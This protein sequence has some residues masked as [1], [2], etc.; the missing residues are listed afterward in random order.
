MNSRSTSASLGPFVAEE[1]HFYLGP[2]RYSIFIFS[3]SSVNRTM[4]VH[5][6]GRDL[7]MRI[8]LVAWSLVTIG[9]LAFARTAKE[10][11]GAV[12]KGPRLC[13]AHC[14]AGNKQS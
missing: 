1:R 14:E 4:S 11:F 5:T 9:L 7:L 8:P 13:D 6:G 12:D 10:V 2:G 3:R